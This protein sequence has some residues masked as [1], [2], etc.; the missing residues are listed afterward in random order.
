MF[1]SDTGCHTSLVESSLGE[2]ALESH[3]TGICTPR[4]REGR[5]VPEMKGGV[6]HVCSPEARGLWSPPPPPNAAPGELPALLIPAGATDLGKQKQQQQQ[7]KENKKGERA[8]FHLEQQTHSRPA[9]FHA[10]K[11]RRG[12]SSS[13]LGFSQFFLTPA[14]TRPRAA[15]AP[16]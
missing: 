11:T 15:P 9:S 1:L 12:R 8:N 3:T 4:G 16:D 6:G 7:Q 2:M 10:L 14:H 5:S 13:E